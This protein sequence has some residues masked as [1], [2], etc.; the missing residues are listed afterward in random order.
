MATVKIGKP[1]VGHKLFGFYRTRVGG[2]ESI[3][4]RRKMGEPTDVMHSASKE[5]QDQRRRFGIASTHY[6][7]LTP[8]QKRDSRWQMRFVSRV[9]HS[10]SEEV[11]LEGRQLFI[12][13]DINEQRVRGRLKKPAFYPCIILCDVAH[14]PL[15]GVLHLWYTKAG[16]WVVKPGKELI[17]GNWLFERVPADAEPYRVWGEADGY[18]DPELPETM[19]MTEDYLRKDH[20]HVLLEEVGYILMAFPEPNTERSS[21]DGQFYKAG[22]YTWSQI[23]AYAGSTP[24]PSAAESKVG[25][26]SYS[27]SGRWAS[28]YR[29]FNLFDTRLLPDGCTIVSAKLI[30]RCLAKNFSDDFDGGFALSSSFPTTNTNLTATD[31]PKVGQVVYSNIIPKEN[32]VVGQDIEFQ[33]NEDG[34]A[35]IQKAG[36]TKLAVREAVYDIPNNQ[37]TWKYPW[38][39]F[40]TIGQADREN[41]TERPR[42]EVLYD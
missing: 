7:G 37:P 6:A 25:L 1:R 16:Q 23:R 28:L 34:L 39:G 38:Y 12:S 13:E 35:A 10:P 33:L 42:L 3:V 27:Q 22:N 41:I 40:V 36:I 17:L 24:Q 4:V 9:G 21:V 5:V 20:Y 26:S 19:S 18:Y 2:D 31:W 8:R 15:D 29:S 11:L 32:F 30:V 14:T